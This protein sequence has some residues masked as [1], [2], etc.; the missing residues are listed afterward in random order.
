MDAPTNA[1]AQAIPIEQPYKRRVWVSVLLAF[2]GAGL[3]LIY[4]GNL[5]G[6]VMLT[7]AMIALEFLLWVLI[8]AFSTLS[9]AIVLI[10]MSIAIGVAIL[11]YII[12]YT[13]KT[14]EF[15]IP[16]LPHAWLWVISI[17][18]IGLG[19]EEVNDLIIKANFVE[20]YKMP[21]GS[22]ENTLMIGD[23]LLASKGIKPEK[24]QRGD[25]IVFKYPNDEKINYIKRIVAICG[26]TVEIINKQLYVNHKAIPAPPEAQFIDP[27]HTYQ[28]TID[29]S[30]KQNYLYG[31]RD[32][33]PESII[34]Q[35]GYFVL[36]DNRDNSADSRYWGLVDQSEVVG[37][38]RF[39]HF[40]W[41]AEHWK[42]RWNRMG[43][44]L[45]DYRQP[46]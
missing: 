17:F 27:M 30:D 5:K 10:F 25:L 15:S 13:R 14:N 9:M 41:D 12:K 44:R 26:D 43:K 21:S 37:K 32:N 4:C 18:L 8:A 36:G 22:M 42:I 39:I 45:D 16:R 1:D 34:A 6:G 20:A 38:A 46:S 2:L 11:I 7:F 29:T 33:M 24:L 35:N 23:Y 40:S 19:L 3:P 31:R 28:Y